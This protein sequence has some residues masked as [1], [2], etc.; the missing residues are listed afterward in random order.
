MRLYE[1]AEKAF[2]MEK[3]RK[4]LAKLF[5]GESE[6]GTPNEIT[7]VAMKA[8]A[9]GNTRYSSAAGEFTLREKLAEKHGVTPENIV[10]TPGSK[11][12]IYSLLNLFV[13]KGNSAVAIAPAWPGFM[14]MANLLGINLKLVKTELENN[15]RP[16]PEAVRKEIRQNGAKMLILNSPNNPTSTCTKTSDL[17]EIMEI[18]SDEGV[19][20]LSDDAYKELSF[21]RTEPTRNHN[22]KH[23]VV[24]SFS[25]TYSMTGWRVGYLVAEKEICEEAITMNQLTFSC[26]PSFVQEGAIA[27]LD[28]KGEPERRRK[29]YSERSKM[30]VKILRRQFELSKPQ[31]G[32]YIFPRRKGL[33]SDKLAQKLVQEGIGVAPGSDFGGYNEFIRISLTLKTEKLEGILERIIEVVENE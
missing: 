6:L 30:A 21:E 14:G 27:A 19:F 4:P 13:G 23:I 26:V 11:F 5:I 18:A 32:F 33:D 3:R 20:V 15:W 7:E 29:I 9:K 16:D 31:A 24:S 10:M 28:L 12:A 2:E 22:P 8:L 1:L 17:E 25:K